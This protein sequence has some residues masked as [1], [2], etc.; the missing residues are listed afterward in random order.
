[1]NDKN[2]WLFPQNSCNVEQFFTTLDFFAELNGITRSKDVQQTLMDEH[3]VKGIYNPYIKKDHHDTSSANHKIDEPRFYG[4]IY[5]T[6][7]KKIHVSTHGE[8]LLRY[9]D[10]IK[11]RNKVFIAMICNIQFDNPYKR[12]K[13]F[14]IYPLRLILQ[15]LLDSKLDKQLSNIE[16]AAILYYVKEVSGPED[17]N[18]IVK[19]IIDFRNADEEVKIKI[20]KNDSEQF[21]KNYVSC[22]YLCNILNGLEIIDLKK[23]R[24]NYKIKSPVRKE[25]TNVNERILILDLEYKEFVENYLK[26]ET[27]FQSIKQLKGLK[28]DWIREIYNSVSQI[29]L[30][31]IQEVDDIYNAYLQIPKILLEASINPTLWKV[32]E[33]YITKSFNLF[34]DVKAESIGG[35]GEPDT[36]CCYINQKNI[37]FCVD[38]KST[39][40]KLSYINDGRLKQHREKY[41]AKYTIVVTPGYVPSAAKDI[42]KTD[43]CIITSYCLADLI[44][45][46]IFKLY[47]KNKSCSYRVINDLVIGNLGTDISDRIYKLIDDELGV[48][49]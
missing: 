22:N 43:T 2:V 23:R 6:P 45:K 38:G 11:K 41:N 25:P 8:L 17:Y 19:D 20:L 10:D 28:S 12:I 21:V 7:N 15:L 1:M 18:K 35:S 31:E 4:A 34:D 26:E 29:L 30:K 9:R 14:N 27:V 13:D 44:T 33:T 36:L 5:E 16:I 39:Q 3:V 48:R 37:Y 32:F 46:Y 47:K 24:T 49:R 42:Y 40:K